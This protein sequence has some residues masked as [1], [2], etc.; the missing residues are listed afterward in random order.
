[1][2]VSVLGTRGWASLFF[3]PSSIAIFF[4]VADIASHES[5]NEMRFS[6]ALD[7]NN[8]HDNTR[9]GKAK[10]KGPRSRSLCVL[11]PHLEIL[12]AGCVNRAS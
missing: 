3:L 10:A 2:K 4:V 6:L 9:M 7:D 1:M 12:G 8:G 5:R 11:V